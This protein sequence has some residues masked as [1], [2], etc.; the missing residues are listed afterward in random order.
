MGLRGK[1]A[2]YIVYS[3]N[4]IG[5][6]REPGTVDQ[7]RRLRELVE[8]INHCCQDRLRS[9]SRRFGLP[10]AELRSLLLFRQE[11]YLAAR[12]MAARLDVNRSRVSKL[13]AGLTDKGLVEAADDPRDGR[14]K[15][16]GLTAKGDRLLTAVSDHVLE[17]HQRVLNYMEPVRRGSVLATLELV[18]SAM[19]SVQ[20]EDLDKQD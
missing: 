16:I 6:N 1:S 14:I 8:D 10:P 9:D 7:A 2:R 19:K 18:W 4:D 17:A 5:E 11:R 3:M 12:D 20:A 13:I 15:L